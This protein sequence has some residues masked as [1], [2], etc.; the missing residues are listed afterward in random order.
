MTAAKKLKTVKMY[1]KKQIAEDESFLF[2]T[3]F[4]ILG[5]MIKTHLTFHNCMEKSAAEQLYKCFLSEMRKLHPNVQN[6]QYAT[7][8]NI[9]ASIV[10][11]FNLLV[12]FR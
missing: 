7:N 1:L 12:E 3:N 11:P 6:G 5:K 8:Y 10:G 9:K 4:T 2:I